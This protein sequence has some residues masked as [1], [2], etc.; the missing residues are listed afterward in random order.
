MKWALERVSTPDDLPVS[1]AEMKL[2]LGV[3]NDI[4]ARDVEIQ[5][6]IA[7]AREWAEDFTGR[8]LFDQ[9]WRLT[10]AP[11]VVTVPDGGYSGDYRPSATGEILLRRS[12]ALAVVSAATVDSVGASEDLDTA[13][14]EIRGAGTKWPSLYPFSGASWGS[15][16]MRIVFRAGYADLSTSPPGDESDIPEC[17]KQAV[18]IYAEA[19]YDRDPDKMS[20][21]IKAAEA[22]IRKERCDLSMA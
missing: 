9:Q 17:F 7:A 14:Y 19:L 13:S 2:N 4:T 21:L 8:A 11:Y 10:I 1:L 20:T 6:K 12:P 15:G 3:G 22:L 5:G 16:E 18:M